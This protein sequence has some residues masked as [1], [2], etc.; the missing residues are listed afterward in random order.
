MYQLAQHALAAVDEDSLRSL[1]RSVNRIK[2]FDARVAAAKQKFGSKPARLFKRIR[3]SLETMSG[4][5]V[6]CSYCEDSCADEVEHVRP[7][8]FF[9]E[10]VFK[11]VNYL[12]ACGICNGGK[13]NKYAIRDA[14]GT[15]VDLPAHRK[16]NGIVPPPLGDH[17]FIDPRKDDPM[18][19]LWL[20]LVG[21]TFRFAVL[22]EHDPWMV[23]RAERTR[24]DLRLN[25]EVL[26]KAR[27]N[28]FSGYQDR[29]AQYVAR[30]AAGDSAS[31]LAN[32]ERELK[33]SPHRT[34]WLEMK[35]QRTLMP[36]LDLLFQQAPEALAW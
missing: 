35:R 18:A 30:K 20:D 36:Q 23:A 10:E 26:V 34:V 33:R 28:A 7:K 2:A 32:R 3:A 31:Q 27:E 14:A 13:N 21:G 4:D 24:D 17:V 16:A 22:D 19:L 6:R 12:F 29:L 8:D 1:Q 11:W 9:P 15:I 5:L 25:R